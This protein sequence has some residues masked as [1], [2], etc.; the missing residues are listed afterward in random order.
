MHINTEREYK[1]A[2]EAIRVLEEEEIPKE[3]TKWREIGAPE[4]SVEALIGTMRATVT[5]L[6]ATVATY[7]QSRP[8]QND[9][10]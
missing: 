6:R 5:Q 9:P 1:E 2:L 3:Q 10:S 4:R 8:Y 7:E